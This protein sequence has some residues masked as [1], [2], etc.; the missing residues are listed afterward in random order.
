M[1]IKGSAGLSCRLGIESPDR[2]DADSGLVVSMRVVV[3]GLEG[4]SVVRLAANEPF[5]APVVDLA[6]DVPIADSLLDIRD[7]E[8]ALAS[9]IS[10]CSVQTKRSI[11]TSQAYAA[12]GPLGTG[13]QT[14]ANRPQTAPM[15]GTGSKRFDRPYSP[16]K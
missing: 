12:A 15:L 4:C 14:P 16:I 6:V 3:D 11:S 5:R 13:A 8:T 7:R 10:A 9:R 1:L 2:D